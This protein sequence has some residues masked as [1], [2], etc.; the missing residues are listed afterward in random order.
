MFD[1]SLTKIISDPDEAA[2]YLVE[3]GVIDAT[4]ENLTCET[5][6][7][8]HNMPSGSST[9]PY[10][11]WSSKRSTQ[12]DHEATKFFLQLRSQYAEKFDDK[13]SVKNQ[14]WALIAKTMNENGFFVGEKK[15][16]VEKCRMKF[17]NL[18]KSYLNY[19]RHINSTGTDKKDPPPYY[20]EMHSILSSK[21]KTNPINLQDTLDPMVDCEESHENNNLA[22]PSC[23]NSRSTEKETA[24]NRFK[25][26]RI[27]PKSN[28][29]KIMEMITKQH[30]ENIQERR[31]QFKSLEN[32]IATQNTQR[33]RL[34]SQFE[35]L[36][37]LEQLKVQKKKRRS[38]SSSS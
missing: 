8:V 19:I 24:E 32:L 17:A 37:E 3:S 1:W 28:T 34:L 29:E 16:A 7:Y 18:Q 35:K 31:E 2:K 25:K 14:L 10:L 15:E 21:D 4:E 20:E 27:T 22:T 11:V 33:D 12:V 9:S 5:T 6:E 30:T 36:I 13:K 23:S 38:D 26:S